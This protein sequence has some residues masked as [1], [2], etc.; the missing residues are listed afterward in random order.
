M[1]TVVLTLLAILFSGCSSVE[2]QKTS[3]PLTAIQSSERFQ[4]LVR[5]GNAVMDKLVYEM[6]TW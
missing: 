2:T 1:R 5:T 6:A 4:L 3:A